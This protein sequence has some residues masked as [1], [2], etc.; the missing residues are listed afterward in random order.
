M[1]AD[2]SSPDETIHSRPESRSLISTKV[3]ETIQ[4]PANLSDT[5][6]KQVLGSAYFGAQASLRLNIGTGYEPLVIVPAHQTFLGRSEQHSVDVEGLYIS[7]LPY[8]AWAKGVSRV[9]TVLRRH[10]ST[11][12]IEDLN[13]TNGTYL[14][15]EKLPPHQQQ[16]LRDGDEVSL[17]SFRMRVAFQYSS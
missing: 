4:L 7:L 17:G 9:H 13:S 16:V 15:G 3:V 6:L 2:H 14:N 8:D 11:I 10:E 12:N 1:T 5:E